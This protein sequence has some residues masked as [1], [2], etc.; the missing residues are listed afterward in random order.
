MMSLSKDLLE[1]DDVDVEREGYDVSKGRNQALA[2]HGL[3]DVIETYLP[4]K[5]RHTE[6]FLP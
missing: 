6:R 2:K 1:Q 4:R 3:N 5:L